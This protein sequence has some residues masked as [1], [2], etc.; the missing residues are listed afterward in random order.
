MSTESNKAIARRWHTDLWGG[1]D[2]DRALALAE[3][4]VAADY[5][6]HAMPPGLA[7]GIA[8][9]KQQLRIFYTG[10]PDIYSTADE[11]IG[12][13]DKVVVRWHG[14]GTHNGE[15][16]GIPPTGAAATTTGIHIFRIADSKIVEHWGNS[17]DLGMLRQLGV[18]PTP[19][20]A[21]T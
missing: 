5:V 13:G 21:A 15:F 10:L 1:G 4:I 6:D 14:G 11:L 17:D 18:I 7:P 2:L 8:G 20:Q 16:F 9:L 19:A 3:Q 12:E